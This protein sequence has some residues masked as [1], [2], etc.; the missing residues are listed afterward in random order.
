[1]NQRIKWVVA[2]FLTNGVFAAFVCVG[3][4]YDVSWMNGVSGGL[5]GYAIFAY[6]VTA[7]D[8]V[9][10]RK[11]R[12]LLSCKGIKTLDTLVVRQMQRVF[13]TW[14]DAACDLVLAV[15]LLLI[16]SP[17]LCAL[18]L[19]EMFAFQWASDERDKIA[20]SR[21]TVHRFD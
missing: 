20:E 9:L 21:G 3:V 19:I 17:F 6:A 10:V 7:C 4:R 11:R 14:V 13:G 8:L 2:W 12:T 5:Y 16:G 15:V 1:M 18:Q